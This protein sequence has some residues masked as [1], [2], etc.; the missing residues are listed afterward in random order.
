[1]GQQQKTTI[2]SFEKKMN[3]K[4]FLLE[5]KTVTAT[6]LKNVFIFK[7]SSIHYH[8]YDVVLHEAQE[9]PYKTSFLACSIQRQIMQ[10]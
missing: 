4:N 5:L 1:M 10:S 8:Q 6:S 7:K 9:Y 2:K 3:G